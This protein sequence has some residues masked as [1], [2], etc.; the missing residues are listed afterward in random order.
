MKKVIQIIL[1]MGIMLCGWST[2]AHAIGSIMGSGN[3]I[4][5][6]SPI[7][8]QYVLGNGTVIHKPLVLTKYNSVSA[9]KG[10]IVN[11]NSTHNQKN[12]II[13]ESNIA[14]L[15]QITIKEAKLDISLKSNI[16]IHPTKPIIVN[17]NTE[18]LSD[19]QAQ[20]SAIINVESPISTTNLTL[21]TKSASS[22][23]LSSIKVS[24]RL[25]IT[26]SSSSKICVRQKST[27]NKTDAESKSSSQIDVGLVVAHTGKANASSASYI[28]INGLD[29]LYAKAT[30]AAIVK[31]TGP[32]K[33]N[34]IQK[35]SGKITRY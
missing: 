8:Q 10:I 26:A 30:S 6:I 24:N 9:S 19:L 2:S 31:Y 29:T 5:P 3:Q 32:A 23:F 18:N 12:E 25:Y 7:D 1:I 20:N 16:L 22:I 17:L 13:A 35:T 4:N 14:D 21:N 33:T 15:V 34:L 27:A 11:I 28:R